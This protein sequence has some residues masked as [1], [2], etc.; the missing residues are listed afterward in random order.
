MAS[1]L[2]SVARMCLCVHSTAKW[3]DIGR[4]SWAYK[5]SKHM[6]IIDKTLIFVILDIC[7]FHSVFPVWHSLK[8]E[9]LLNQLGSLYLFCKC[10]NLIHTVMQHCIMKTHLL[11]GVKANWNCCYLWS[12]YITCASILRKYRFHFFPENPEK[13]SEVKAEI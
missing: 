3:L 13:F 7:S 9:S 10:Q 5:R 8:E 4:H 1:P 12:L 11:S 6:L 2:I